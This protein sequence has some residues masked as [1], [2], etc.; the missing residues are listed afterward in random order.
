MEEKEIGERERE[1]RK[2]EN[3]AVTNVGRGNGMR[4]GNR[5]GR[6]ERRTKEGRRRVSYAA[7]RNRWRIQNMIFESDYLV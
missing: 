4:K 1:W 2:K 7:D 3:Q 5:K 6:R